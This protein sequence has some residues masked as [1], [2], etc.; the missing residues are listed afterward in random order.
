MAIFTIQFCARSCHGLAAEVL[1][2]VLDLDLGSGMI[3]PREAWA[4][5]LGLAR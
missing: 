5:S 1:R 2:C 3:D 4:L